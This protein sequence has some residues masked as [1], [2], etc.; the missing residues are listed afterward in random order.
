MAVSAIPHSIGPPLR[1]ELF[2]RLP[3]LGLIHEVES[4]WS[5]LTMT[6]PFHG[7]AFPACYGHS[8]GVEIAETLEI[9]GECECGRKQG[10]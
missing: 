1:P 8:S 4:L 3:R 7:K 6:K 2:T 5:P 9:A 10:A